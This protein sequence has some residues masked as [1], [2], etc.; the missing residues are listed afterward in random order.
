MLIL[1]LLGPKIAYVSLFASHLAFYMGQKAHCEAK[2]K[3]IVC[4]Y[5]LLV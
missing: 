5:L 3:Q 2:Y 4:N 1:G